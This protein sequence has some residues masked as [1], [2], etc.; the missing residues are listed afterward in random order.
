MV[1]ATPAREGRELRHP[2][3]TQT[4]RITALTADGRT[5]TLRA[6]TVGQCFATIGQVVANGRVIAETQLVGYGFDDTALRFAR[7]LA[8]AI[9]AEQQ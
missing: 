7:A 9:G 6:R 8:E 1:T 3:T 4:P 2:M 5:V